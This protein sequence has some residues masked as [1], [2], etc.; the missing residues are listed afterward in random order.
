M[1]RIRDSTPADAQIVTDIINRDQPEPLGVEQVRERLNA[2]RTAGAE[3]RMVA[4]TDDGQVVGYGH[5]LRDDWMEPGLFWTNIAVAHAARRQGIGSLIHDALL[6]WLR[7]RH[8]TSLRADVYEHLPESLRFAERH[9]YQ[10]ERHIFE[11]TLDLSAFDER[12]LL[13]ALGAARAAGIR[14]ATMADLGDTE[15]ARRKL[16]DVESVTARDIPGFSE[17]AVRPFETFNREVCEAAG[18]RPD[19]QS[20]ALDG[21]MWV[22]LARLDP[23]E[24]TEAMYNGITGV[25]PAWRGRGIALALKLLAIRAARR[26]GARYLRTNNDSENAPMLAV[27]RKLGYQPA[28]GYYRMR[29]RLASAESAPGVAGVARQA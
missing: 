18:Y 29:A 4:E 24:A 23:T 2:P 15:E 12:P 3:W 17:S 10:I 25:L 20:V 27:N 5:A 26:Y 11:S 8:A 19:C 1:V 14:F 13:G 16:W 9:G 22:G 6:G 21:D 28:P 7:E